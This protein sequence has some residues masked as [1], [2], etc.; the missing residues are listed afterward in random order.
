MFTRK[1][2]LEYFG[3]ILKIEESMRNKGGVLMR[4][5]SNSEAKSILTELVADEKRHMSIVKNIIKI[6]KKQGGTQ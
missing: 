4:K 5:I 3:E 6:I 2:F 1:D